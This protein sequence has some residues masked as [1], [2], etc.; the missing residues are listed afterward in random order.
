MQH[1]DQLLLQQSPSTAQHGPARNIDEVQWLYVLKFIHANSQE[2]THLFNTRRP[3]KRVA[4][5][6]ASNLKKNRG[7]VI[8]SRKK[9]RGTIRMKMF[10][11]I[12]I[13]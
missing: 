3:K 8:I 4:I 2:I 7:I 6:E 13:P 9:N 11:I 12:D 5:I 10:G 1:Q